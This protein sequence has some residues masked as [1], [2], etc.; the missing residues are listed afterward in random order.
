[1]KDIS[2]NCQFLKKYVYLCSKIKKKRSEKP[3]CDDIIKKYQKCLEDPKL[4]GH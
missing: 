1:M 4:N 3:Y 2:L